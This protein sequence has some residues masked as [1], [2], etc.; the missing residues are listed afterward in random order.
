[1]NGSVFLLVVFLFCSCKKSL[2]KSVIVADTVNP[3]EQLSL[4]WNDFSPNVNH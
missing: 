3:L 4:R 2:S 1:M